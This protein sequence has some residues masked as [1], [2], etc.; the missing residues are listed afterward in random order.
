MVC[1]PNKIA[2]YANTREYIFKG[3]CTNGY[4]PIIKEIIAVPNDFVRMNQKGITVNGKFYN[5]KQQLLD[6]HGRFLQPKTM[7]QKIK[8]YLLIGYNS[9]NSWDS[10]YFGTVQSKNIKGVMR[11]IYTF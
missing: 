7:N 1:L 9:P 11:A 10:R 6:S 3:S 4:S 8:G 2:K 5:L